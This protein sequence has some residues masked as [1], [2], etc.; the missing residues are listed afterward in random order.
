[1]TGPKVTLED[2]EANVVNEH[3]FTAA[4][5]VYGALPEHCGM[6][7]FSDDAPEARLTFCVLVLKNGFTVTGESACVSVDNFNFQTGKENARKR[8]LDKVWELLAFKLSSSLAEGG[9]S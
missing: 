1:M 2:V 7:S 3:Y 8:A 5:G 6:T 4:Q 9:A